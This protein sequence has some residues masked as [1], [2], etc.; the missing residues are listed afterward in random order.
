M[1][2]QVAFPTAPEAMPATPTSEL[3]AVV[4]RLY[5][6][7][8][9]WA[10][11][12]V[13]ERIALLDRLLDGVI[14]GADEWG[15]LDGRAKGLWPGTPEAGEAASN[16]P[17]PTARMIRLLRQSL[18]GVRDRGVPPIPPDRLSERPDGRLVARVMPWDVW[19]R[20]G[21]M[22]YQAEVWMQPGVTRANLRENQAAAYREL[23]F[24]GKVALVLGAGNQSSI[25]V[26]DAI[27]KLF[28]DNQVVVLK[29]NPVN[30]YLGPLFRRIFQPLVDQGWLEVV[31]GG[32]E[33]GAHLCRHEAVH[34]IHITGSDKTH[35]AIVWGPKDEQAGR[36]DR[37]EPLLTKEISSELGNVTPIVVVPGPWT[38]REIA[39]QAENVAT[40]VVNNASFNCIAGKVLVTPRDWD[41]RDAFLAAVRAALAKVPSR[42]A[43]YPGARDRWQSFV[44]AY[45]HAERLSP[46][47]EGTVPWTFIPDLDPEH[48]G[49]AFCVEPFCGVLHEVP[50]AG[51]HAV[52]FLPRAVQFCNETV[53]GTLGI[54][55]LVHPSTRKDPAAEAALQEGLDDLRYGTIAVNHWSGFGYALGTTTWGAYP[56][57]PL[58]DI[59]SGRGVVHNALLFDRPQKS[60]IYGPFMPLVKPMWWWNHRRMERYA[61]EIVKFQARPSLWGLLRV[62]PVMLG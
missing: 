6:R 40:M 34:T 55:L 20:L 59:G 58:E 56:G 44:S 27:H 28:V 47:A 31:Y 41:R 15:Q 16:G 35:D 25:P 3:D 39:F 9:A 36:K 60:V 57:H 46:E 18:V 14:A 13:H 11:V 23:D 45:G 7:R 26:L 54:T 19:D 22:G 24:E 51:R 52:E 50:L 2:S 32:A 62:S 21:F 29:M 12:P 48:E 42:K 10:Q 1:P 38:D 4:E 17:I 37:G 30:E 8:A 61:H 49:P 53:W 43:F 33:Q 5:A